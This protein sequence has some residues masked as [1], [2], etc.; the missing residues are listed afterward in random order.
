MNFMPQENIIEHLRGLEG[1]VHHTYEGNKDELVYILARLRSVS[2]IIG[3]VINPAFDAEPKIIDFLYSFNNR[4]N[5][6]LFLYDSLID[7]D[8]RPLMGPLTDEE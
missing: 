2:F 7:Y 5:G 6:L 4:L 3:M 8:G 1:Y